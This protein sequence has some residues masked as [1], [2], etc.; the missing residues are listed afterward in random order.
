MGNNCRSNKGPHLDSNQG[1]LRVSGSH[2][3]ALL[4]ERFHTYGLF[5]LVR[6][7]GFD[8]EKL[9]HQKPR[10][11][12]L[13]SDWSDVS[14]Q[15]QESKHRKEATL[16]QGRPWFILRLAV[17]NCWCHSSAAVL[18]R[19]FSFSCFLFDW[20]RHRSWLNVC[21]VDWF[22]WLQS[23]QD[24]VTCFYASQ[25]VCQYLKHTLALCFSFQQDPTC[26]R[27]LS[28]NRNR[29][30]KHVKVLIWPELWH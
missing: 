18:V 12:V 8:I 1:Q 10:E 30:W 19:P 29:T 16:V 3:S 27:L 25:C 13:S 28:N 23:Y 26:D 21:H 11:N 6:I 4:L 20:S 14:G 9:H 2:S 15:E 24:K 22:I 17:S 7:S 5:A